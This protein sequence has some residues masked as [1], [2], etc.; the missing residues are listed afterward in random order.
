MTQKSTKTL[1]EFAIFYSQGQYKFAKLFISLGNFMAEDQDKDSSQKTEEPTQRR[2]EEAIKRGHVAFSKE[3]TSFLF[4]LFLTIS[5]SLAIPL[6][7]KYLAHRISFYINDFEVFNF[8][9]PK[10]M[11]L[12]VKR[13]MFDAL[14]VLTLPMAI[15]L[16]AS[17]GGSLI[18]NGIIFSPEAIE[19]KLEKISPL[20]GFKRIFSKKSLSEFIKGIIKISVIGVISYIVI[21]SEIIYILNSAE[22]NLITGLW[23]FVELSLKVM[24]GISIAMAF[25]AVIDYL[26]ER[27]VYLESLKMTKQEVKEELKQTE[28]N[29]EIKAKRRRIMGERVRK[30]MLKAV[31]T[32]TV[33]ITNPTHFSV[34]LR[35][36]MNSKTAPQV[37]AKGQDYLALKIRE[38]AKQHNIPLVENAP[39][40]RALFASVEIDEFI[41]YEFYNAVAGILSKIVKRKGQKIDVSQ[42]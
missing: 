31:P 30:N 23:L 5:I 17:F 3:V 37:V 8:S 9:N 13:I 20:S 16:V 36:D 15:N 41:P 42:P 10:D 22:S 19:P 6:I 14:T 27:H 32:A 4:I 38:I 40:A 21:Q 35:Y 34:A 1:C 29:P 11:Q 7:A 24:I 2:L 33:V 28:G 26:F 12:M 39:L 25:I 18:Q